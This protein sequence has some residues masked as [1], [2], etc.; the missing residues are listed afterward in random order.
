MIDTDA[1][2]R[3]L[4][5]L[6]DAHAAQDS[7]LTDADADAV[8]LARAAVLAECDAAGELLDDRE[9]VMDAQTADDPERYL[10]AEALRREGR[11]AG[12]EALRL[13]L[14]AERAGTAPGPGT[15]G[16]GRRRG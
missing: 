10:S 7:D 6:A 12:R 8:N 5:N 4:A 2:R 13:V 15:A 9:C 16:A 11:T 1:L 3:A 14:I